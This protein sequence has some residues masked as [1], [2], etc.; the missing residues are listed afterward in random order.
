MPTLQLAIS[1]RV[2]SVAWNGLYG[3]RTAKCMRSVSA[4][5]VS[6]LHSSKPLSTCE[7]SK[8]MH[9]LFSL[10]YFRHAS[11]YNCYYLVL[12]YFS[13]CDDFSISVK[14]DRSLEGASRE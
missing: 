11:M 3:P 7:H 4:V 13:Y 12:T 14:D 8:T 2:F 9:R 5:R 6:V 10:F 1:F